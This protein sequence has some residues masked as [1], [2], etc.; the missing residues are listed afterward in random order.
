MRDLVLEYFVV[1]GNKYAAESFAEEAGIRAGPSVENIDERVRIN[2]LIY[3]GRILEAIDKLNAINRSILEED[4]KLHFSLLQQ[5]YIE[6]LRAGESFEALLFSRTELGPFSRVS[7][8]FEEEVQSCLALL[9]FAN[10]SSRDFPTELQKYFDFDTRSSLVNDVNRA[11]LKNF[12]HGTECRLHQLLRLFEMK[13][14]EVGPKLRDDFVTI[15]GL[16]SIGK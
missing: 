14:K 7:A 15:S 5:H 11:V 9:L 1:T 2:E 6:L 12:S 3:D 13:Q 10:G 4:R 16:A 8:E